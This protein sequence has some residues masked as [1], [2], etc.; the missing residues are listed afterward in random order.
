M[1]KVMYAWKDKVLGCYRHFFLTKELVELCS[2][3]KFVS[4]T[5]K[6][7]GNIVRIRIVEMELL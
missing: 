5:I 6:N 2:S 1:K 3:D 7:E 4:Q